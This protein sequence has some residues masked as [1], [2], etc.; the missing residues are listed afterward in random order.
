MLALSRSSRGFARLLGSSLRPR[1][2]YLDLNKFV[3][4]H[5]FLRVA[6][7]VIHEA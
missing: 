5:T 1:K 7:R 4:W 3:L 2:P 6:A